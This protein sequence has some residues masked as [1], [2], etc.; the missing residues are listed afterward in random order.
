MK[1]IKIKSIFLT[2]EALTDR[3]KFL[4][5]KIIEYACRIVFHAWWILGIDYR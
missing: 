3:E 2:S 5:D 4:T 1:F